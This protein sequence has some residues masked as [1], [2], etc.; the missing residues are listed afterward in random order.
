[1]ITILEINN[2]DY[3]LKIENL[4]QIFRAMSKEQI[5]IFFRYI[6]GESRQPRYDVIVGTDTYIG[7]IINVFEKMS[8]QGIIGY[9][10]MH[11]C[12]KCR[13]AF[14]ATKDNEV[15][16]RRG[17][18][19]LCKD[20]LQE[21]SEECPHCH[22]RRLK[23][24][25]VQFVAD[26]K[27]IISCCYKGIHEQEEHLHNCVHCR[28]L[29][30][31]NS[32][33][34]SSSHTLCPI[35]R[36]EFDVCDDCGR[37]VEKGKLIN[38]ICERCHKAKKVKDAIKSYSYKPDPKFICAKEENTPIEYM[39]LEWEMELIAD[40]TFKK[41]K[42]KMVENDE[43]LEDRRHTFFAYELGELGKDWAYCKSDGS[44]NY[45]VEFVTHPITLK[46][47]I[48]DYYPKLLSIS[49]CMKAWGCRTKA[50]TAGIHVHF[51]RSKLDS[52]TIKRICWLL[53]QTDNFEFMRK[54]CHRNADNMNHWAKRH[55]NWSSPLDSFMPDTNNRY[56]IVNLCNSH[57]IEFRCFGY[58]NNADEIM[59]YLYAVDSIVNYCRDH[60][61]QDVEKANMIEVLTYRNTEKMV[62]Y[63][64][65]RSDLEKC[66]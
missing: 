10:K 21:L 58:T 59:I 62:E 61:N 29:F 8:K 36:D 7:S 14:I 48:E 27:T 33:H 64:E 12:G 17:K 66:V 53:S 16:T 32:W 45:G 26:D 43:W 31:N 11:E 38:G 24:E 63:L 51:S 40:S 46:A 37:P 20:C 5:D 2:K 52:A 30:V 44:L 18:T 15:V 55:S 39:G 22:S 25:V 1:M 6:T 60:K 19:I 4:S 3:V 47:W 49:E 56:K 35:C 54:F 42:H 34:F 28:R 41:R 57:T 65:K 9:K 50:A 23:T 13:K